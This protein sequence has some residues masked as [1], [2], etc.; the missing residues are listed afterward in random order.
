MLKGSVAQDYLLVDVRSR[1][2]GSPQDVGNLKMLPKALS[3][4]KN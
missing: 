4:L 2:V 1:S 3:L